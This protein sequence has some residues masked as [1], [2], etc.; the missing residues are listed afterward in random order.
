MNTGRGVHALA[1]VENGD[2]GERHALMAKLSSAIR[3]YVVDANLAES[4]ALTSTEPGD[5]SIEVA[6]SSPPNTP[7]DVQ[8]VI[9]QPAPALVFGATSIVK[10]DEA[11]EDDADRLQGPGS[12]PTNGSPTIRGSGFWNFEAEEADN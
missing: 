6:S 7:D 1:F 10:K 2:S 9:E 11:T 12:D 8:Q 4:V 5:G 3:G